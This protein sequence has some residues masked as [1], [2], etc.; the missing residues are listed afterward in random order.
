MKTVPAAILA[1]SIGSAAYGVHLNSRPM[2]HVEPAADRQVGDPGAALLAER[3][4]IGRAVRSSDGRYL[5]DVAGVNEDNP[6]EFYVDIAD[7]L[8]LGE[9]RISLL[10]DQLEEIT[11]DRIVLRLTEPEARNSRPPDTDGEEL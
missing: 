5:G 10:S 9:R 3:Q 11:R 1:A 2:D 6:L 4:W 7:F 8:A